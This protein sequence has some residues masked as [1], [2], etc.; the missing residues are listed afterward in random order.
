MGRMNDWLQIQIIT[1]SNSAARCANSGNIQWNRFGTSFLR[2]V[3][4]KMR[5]FMSMSIKMEGRELFKEAL[6][7]TALIEPQ[8]E[9]SFKTSEWVTKFPSQYSLRGMNRIGK[10]ASGTVARKS[11]TSRILLPIPTKPLCWQWRIFHIAVK[12]MAVD[13]AT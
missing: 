2:H 1:I 5:C 4:A 9:A 7:Q 10:C 13:S 3:K 12:D 6:F 11:R 8:Q